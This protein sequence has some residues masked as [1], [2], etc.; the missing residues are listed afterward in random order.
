MSTELKPKRDGRV[1]SSELELAEWFGQYAAS[2]LRGQETNPYSPTQKPELYLAWDEGWS[3]LKD[4][5]S[6]IGNSR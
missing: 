6:Q 5:Q 1:R 2:L 4:S 3:R